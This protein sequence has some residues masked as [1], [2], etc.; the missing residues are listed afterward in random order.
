MNIL[1]QSRRK[2]LIALLITMAGG[3]FLL[4]DLMGGTLLATQARDSYTLQTWNWLQGRIYIANGDYYSWLELA[5]YNVIYYVSFPPIPSVLLIPWVLVYGMDVP[6]NLVC[7][8]YGMI[9][10]AL[11]YEI[12]LTRGRTPATAAFWALFTVWGS[13]MLWMTT[14]GSVWFQAQALNML[15][16]L[17]GVLAAFR[18]RRA[19]ATT[20]V[21][22]AVGCR[23]MSAVFLPILF[24]MFVRQDQLRCNRWQ[25]MTANWRCLIG[26]IIV[27]IGLMAYN[28]ARFGN[29]LEFGHNYLPEFVRAE[30][31]QFHISYFWPNLKRILFGAVTVT[32]GQLTFSKYNGFMFYV[33]NPLYIVMLAYAIMG[34]RRRSERGGGLL[35]IGIAAELCLLCMHRTMGGWQF[36]ARYTCDML[37]FA[38]MYIALRDRPHAK[39]WEL[40]IGGLAVAFNAYGVMWMYLYG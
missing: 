24:F 4:S 27:A 32:D 17:A 9:S 16:C 39:S 10:A 31:G 5:I 33:A 2:A 37:P 18:G 8:L 20:F 29:P 3:Y 28:F 21:A 36:G 23:P 25:A 6:S 1:S 12:M 15:F 14:D 11:A 7:G 40:A 30:N 38:L 19:W 26:P 35:L 34:I 13:N 22:L